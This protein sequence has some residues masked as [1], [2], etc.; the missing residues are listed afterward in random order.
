MSDNPAFNRLMH[1]VC[2]VHGWCGSAV[3]GQRFHVDD[4]IPD[5]GPIS[6]DQFIDWLFIAEGMDPDDDPQ[7]WGKHKTLLKRAFILH[8]GAEIVDASQLKWYL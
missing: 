4:L 1:D 3:N 8:M 2:V 5:E 6:A 7:K